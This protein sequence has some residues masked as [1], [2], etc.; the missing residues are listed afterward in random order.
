[1]FRYDAMAASDMFSL[2]GAFNLNLGIS[3]FRSPTNGASGH[4]AR[5]R[6]HGFLLITRDGNGEVTFAANVMRSV[7]KKTFKGFQGCANAG[8]SG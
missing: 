1:M 6:C 7:S 2:R 3:S 8:V 5:N 4:C